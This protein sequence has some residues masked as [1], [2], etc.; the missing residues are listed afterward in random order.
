[1]NQYQV[2]TEDAIV[3]LESSRA[4]FLQGLYWLLTAAIALFDGSFVGNDPPLRLVVRDRR[5]GEILH[6]EGPYFGAEAVA[7]ADEAARVIRVLGVQAY[8]RREES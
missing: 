3:S 2:V 7:A 4:W 6:R 1:M 8:I 5:S